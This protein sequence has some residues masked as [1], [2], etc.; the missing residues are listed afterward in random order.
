MEE[1]RNEDEGEGVGEAKGGRRG[2]RERRRNEV[3]KM[4]RKR[5]GGGE[6]YTSTFPH[7]R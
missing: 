2:G 6:W 5:E 4:R 7:S 3:G 1:S